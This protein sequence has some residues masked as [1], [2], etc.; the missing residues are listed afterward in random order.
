MIVNGSQMVETFKASPVIGLVALSVMPAAGALVAAGVGA[1][2]VVNEFPVLVSLP[3][4]DPN[5]D[6]KA[7]SVGLT[8]EFASGPFDV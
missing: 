5:A 4:M 3:P 7:A 8:R 1:L 2:V 6:P